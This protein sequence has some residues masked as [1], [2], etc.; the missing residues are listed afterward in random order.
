MALVTRFMHYRLLIFILICCVRCNVIDWSTIPTPPRFIHEPNDPTIYFTLE[1]T[2]TSNGHNLDYLKERTLRCIAD[3]NPSPGYKWKKN[4]KPFNLALYSDR[5]A[6]RPNEGSFVFS[7]LTAADEGV[8]Q[9]EA[10][11]DNGTAISEKITLKQ[12]C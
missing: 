1:S 7:K 3:G 12:T 6:Q 8:Y 9:C 10:T 2:Q 5:I 4:G 11:N